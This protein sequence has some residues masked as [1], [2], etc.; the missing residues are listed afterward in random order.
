MNFGSKCGKSKTQQPPP[1]MGA[2]FKTKGPL[3]FQCLVE[4]ELTLPSVIHKRTCA[5]EYR[6][7]PRRF[8]CAPQFTNKNLP[9]YSGFAYTCGITKI[10]VY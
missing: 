2:K 4:E 8:P 10:L 5:H 7:F 3:T 6:D 9:I 1:M